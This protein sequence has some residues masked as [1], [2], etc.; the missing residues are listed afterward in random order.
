MKRTNQGTIDKEEEPCA[1]NPKSRKYFRYHHSK[2]SLDLGDTC[3]SKRDT[4]YTKSRP[5]QNISHYCPIVNFIFWVKFK[6]TLMEVPC[7]LF[8]LGLCILAGLFC[9]LCLIFTYKW[10]NTRHVLLSLGYLTQD[11]IDLICFFM[12]TN[13]FEY[14]YF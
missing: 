2:V 12:M 11:A 6:H 5:A 9:T 8:S 3:A 1:K 10:L 7:Y 14:F 13:E 4:W